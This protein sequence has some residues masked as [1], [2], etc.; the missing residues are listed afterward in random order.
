MLQKEPLAP[1]REWHR[2]VIK[3]AA[4][5]Y[6]KSAHEWQQ[7][8]PLFRELVERFSRPGDLVADPFAGSGTTLRA[9][10]A[11]GRHA[12]GADDGSADH[13][14]HQVELMT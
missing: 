11:A 7:P 1:T 10:I 8:E 13:L 9:A 2:D 3:V 4:G 5:D 12:W 6:D 14:R